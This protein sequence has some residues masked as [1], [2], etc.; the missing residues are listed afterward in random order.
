MKIETLE[1]VHY[2]EKTRTKEQKKKKITHFYLPLVF[3]LL[4]V[5]RTV[6]YPLGFVN[7]TKET[8]RT[9][10]SPRPLSPEGDV[11]TQVWRHPW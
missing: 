1:P 10:D 8:N 2:I 4:I 7:Q 9:S 3:F 6:D 11:E 5:P